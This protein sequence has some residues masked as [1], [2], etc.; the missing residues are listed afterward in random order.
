MLHGGGD[1]AGLRAVA[2]PLRLRILS[3]LTGEE[4]STSELA[5]RLGESPANVSFHVRKLQAAGL[6]TLVGTQAVRGGT[7]KIYRHVVQDREQ[8]RTGIGF[9]PLAHGM[10][11]EL[12][13]RAMLL[14]PE[15][16]PV[17]TDFEGVVDAGT[18]ERVRELAR[19]LG[20][21]LESGALPAGAEGERVA[22]SLAVFP[23]T[24]P[25]T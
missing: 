13:R 15:G 3:L 17:F 22:V 9:A 4:L 2:H 7:A 12:A 5:R 11:R 6:L 14:P 16:M 21:V 24:A 25:A 8:L 19:Q 1:E 20:E 18:A 10:G 23:V